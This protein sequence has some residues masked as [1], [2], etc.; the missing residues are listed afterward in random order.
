MEIVAETGPDL[1]ANHNIPKNVAKI[2][3]QFG[4]SNAVFSPKCKSLHDR[5]YIRFIREM[6]R[7]RPNEKDADFR[8]GRF[9]WLF[10]RTQP[11]FEN[12]IVQFLPIVELFGFL[13]NSLKGLG[14][15]LQGF[16][17]G[18][19]AGGVVGLK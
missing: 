16:A 19:S 13:R 11:C 3:D 15:L 14:R 4:R 6:V 10:S 7:P 18:R 9:A 17:P 12:Q 8:F 2:T 1:L 5:R